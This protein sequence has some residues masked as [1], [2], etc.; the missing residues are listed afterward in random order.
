MKFIKVTA[1]E[2]T[3]S[4]DVF[5]VEFL[6][7]TDMIASMT[8]DGEINLKEDGNLNVRNGF[9]LGDRVSFGSI[10]IHHTIIDDFL[11]KYAHK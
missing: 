11:N 4:G 3:N 6:L 10:K 7:N 1:K 5:D 2:H 9:L 8:L